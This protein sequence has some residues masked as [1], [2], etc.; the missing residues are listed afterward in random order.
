MATFELPELPAPAVSPSMVLGAASPLWGYF[1]AATAGGLAWWW[2]A[3]LARPM[4][5]EAWFARSAALPEPV[6]VLLEPVVEAAESA[7]EMLEAVGEAANAALIPETPVGGESAPLSPFVAEPVA[8]VQPE[9]VVASPAAQAEPAAPLE[10]VH[11]AET[12][13]ASGTATDAALSATTAEAA[14]AEPP[15]DPE[16]EATKPARVRVRRPPLADEA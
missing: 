14:G 1:G 6:E 11:A 12:P 9:P 5:L 4:N 7:A 13:A 16:T 10:A 15:G 2:M 3:Q 8:E